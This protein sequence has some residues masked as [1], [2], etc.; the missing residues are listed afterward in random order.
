MLRAVG[1]TYFGVTADGD[2]SFHFT[3]K[4]TCAI[5]PAGAA[6]V[7][8]RLEPTPPLPPEQALSKPA[9][10]KTAGTRAI[11]RREAKPLN[12]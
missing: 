4:V 10:A 6:P 9:I 12:E 7:L 5:W 3:V 11:C 2:T 1:G 8:G